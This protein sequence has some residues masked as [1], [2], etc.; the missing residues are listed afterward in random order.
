M[1]QIDIATKQKIRIYF[2][3]SGFH[4]PLLKASFSGHK[5]I[6]AIPVTNKCLQ[7]GD[8]VSPINT[9]ETI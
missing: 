9:L 3:L 1:S 5:T 6:L 8:S 2:M 4:S 7:N